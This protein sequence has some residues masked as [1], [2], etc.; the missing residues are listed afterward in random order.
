MHICANY[1][2]AVTWWF[3]TSS[4]FL[5]TA[6]LMSR[7]GRI[8][9]VSPDR[10]WLVTSFFLSIRPYRKRVL[11]LS[12]WF[13]NLY[14]QK[15]WLIHYLVEILLIYF[16]PNFFLS[17]TLFLQNNTPMKIVSFFFFH[18]KYMWTFYFSFPLNFPFSIKYFNIRENLKSSRTNSKI[19]T[20]PDSNRRCW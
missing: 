2:F 6:E 7:I 9:S 12:Y 1:T 16:D 18:M 10:A 3:I 19:L 11:I 13:W 15:H 14:W 17:S 8:I 20:M 5:A 4:A